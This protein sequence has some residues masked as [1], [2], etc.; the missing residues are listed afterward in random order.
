MW[1]VDTMRATGLSR[2]SNVTFSQHRN[3][4]TLQI[5]EIQCLFSGNAVGVR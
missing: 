1:A 5:R 2:I 3:V 4:K